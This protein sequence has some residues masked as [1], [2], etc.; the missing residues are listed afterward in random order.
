[1]MKKEGTFKVEPQVIVP[2]GIEKYWL[3]V[4]GFEIKVSRK[5]SGKG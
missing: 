1:M 2:K 4:D 5:K 3:D